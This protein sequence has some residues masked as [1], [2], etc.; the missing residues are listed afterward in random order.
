MSFP[1]R[2]SGTKCADCQRTIYKDE[3]IEWNQDD[4]IIGSRCCG[5]GDEPRS[6]T[7]DGLERV[8]PQGKTRADMCARCFQIPSSSGVCGC[9][10]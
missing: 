2:F 9:D 3:L 4:E 8:L 7:A 6:V 1:A 5:T 10:Q